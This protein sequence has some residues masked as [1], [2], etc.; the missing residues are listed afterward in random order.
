MKKRNR[1]KFDG[2][3]SEKRKKFDNWQKCK[4]NPPI[5]VDGT[6]TNRKEKKRLERFIYET[7][8]DEIGYDPTDGGG[9]GVDWTKSTESV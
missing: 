3:S 9:S 2:F 8:N 1:D 4:L 7:K 5:V 6:M